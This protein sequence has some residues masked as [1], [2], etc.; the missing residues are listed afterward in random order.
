MA[1]NYRNFKTLLNYYEYFENKP[2]IGVGVSGGPDSIAL[3]FL[4]SKWIKYKKGKLTAIVFD[5]CIRHN[6]KI[7][8]LQV[9]RMLQ[10]LGI[11]S[12]IIRPKTNKPIKKNMSNARDNRFEGLIKLCKKN[13]ILH[14]FLGH[15]FDDNIETYLMRK[16]NGSNLDGLESIN[17][18]A[19][20]KNI[21][22]LRPLIETDKKSILSFNKNNKLKFLTDPTNND[23]NY[24]RVKLRNFLQNSKYKREVKKDFLNI[25]KQIPE[26]K[27]MI[28]E[29][30]IDNLIYV[31]AT[32]IKISLNNLMKFDDLIIEK[33]ILC[34]LKFFNKNKAKTKSSK[35]MIFIDNLKKPSF[36]TFNLSGIVIKKNSEFLVFSEK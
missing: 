27:K 28:W 5:H 12:L 26:Y 33:H 24:T 21:Q 15:H 20:F 22:I 4:L 11:Y 32:K 2:H 3:A 8:S 10:D 17:K 16:I 7:E 25:K 23:I 35:I 18:T 9:K 6:S 34:L 19:Y 13:N 36:K 31:S 29:S 30:L 14:L 1:L